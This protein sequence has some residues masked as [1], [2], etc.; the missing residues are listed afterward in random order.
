MDTDNFVLSINTKDI[1]KDL[2]NYEDTIDFSNL[3][4]NHELFS[5][6]RKRVIGKFK[7]ET[8]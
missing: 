6:K 8:T 5:N 3:N 1:I 2:K 7:N 4:A